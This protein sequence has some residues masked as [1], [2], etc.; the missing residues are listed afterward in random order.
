VEGQA[1]T[2]LAEQTIL[3]VIYR[4]TMRNTFRLNRFQLLN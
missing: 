4:D 1:L 3:A 2:K